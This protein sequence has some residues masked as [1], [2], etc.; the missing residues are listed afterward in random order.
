[1]NF[2]MIRQARNRNNVSHIAALHS[3]IFVEH[4]I[5]E[6]YWNMLMTEVGNTVNK[7]RLQYCVDELRHRQTVA[8][9]SVLKVI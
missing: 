5:R 6:M 2:K 1:M 9:S 3:N 4:K 7:R 8:D